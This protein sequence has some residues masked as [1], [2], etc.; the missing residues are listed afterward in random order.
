[1]K[2]KITLAAIAALLVGCG[3]ETPP[4]PA[5]NPLLFDDITSLVLFEQVTAAQESMTGD[6]KKLKTTC[7]QYFD[8]KA[9]AQI[10]GAQATRF[11]LDKGV[12]GSCRPYR[13]QLASHVSSNSQ[14]KI[15]APM[16]LD[17]L[18][19]S[20][21]GEG[22]R[23][24]FLGGSSKSRAEREARKQERRRE[25]KSEPTNEKQ[26]PDRNLPGQF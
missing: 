20:K 6:A 11:E 15:T 8:N 24:S 23:S 22:K 2:L 10:L 3:A 14:S 17:P 19:W 5:D 7:R 9:T 18:V 16:F 25:K 13:E 12:E 26:A 1:M 4:P 21:V